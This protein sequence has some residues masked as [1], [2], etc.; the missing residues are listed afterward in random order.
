MI[1]KKSIWIDEHLWQKCKMAAAVTGD[2][3]LDLMTADGFIVQ[4]VKEYLKKYERYTGG[5]K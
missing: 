1:I 5:V 2:K 4:A 3:G